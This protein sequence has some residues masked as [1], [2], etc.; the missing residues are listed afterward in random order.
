ME[1]LELDGVLSDA[2][3]IAA[4]RSGDAAAFG[5]LYERHGGAAWVVA[6][7]YTRSDADA[8]DVTSEAFSAV[9][10]ALRNG[11]GPDAAFR[12]YLFTCVRNAAAGRHRAVQRTAPTD[13]TAVLEAAAPSAPAA[14][15]P[16]VLGAER[17]MVARAFRSLPERWQAVLWHTEVEGQAPAQV[18]PLLGLSANGV[19]ALAYRAREGLRQ[20]YLQEHL[21]GD[22]PDGCRVVAGKLG[23]F[24]RNGLG[25]RENTTVEAHLE[26]CDRCRALVFELSD[27]SHGMRAVIAPLV[28]GAVGLGALAHALP[29]GG[30]VA[31]G[32]A[33]LA[34]TSGGAAMAAGGTAAAAAAKFGGSAAVGLGGATTAGTGAAGAAGAVAA[35]TAGA[36]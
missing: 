27:V 14:D 33:V 17:T 35:G 16:T 31:A 25:R 24:V 22:L 19:A 26:G 4:T 13:D 8:D 36:G 2:E 12:A 32:V 3:L 11:G 23:P 34:G 6:R 9:L 20:A 10:S 28:L 5:V 29:V 1:G 21:Q 18:A 15:E 7:Q 30:G